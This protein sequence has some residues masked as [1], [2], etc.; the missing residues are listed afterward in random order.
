MGRSKRIFITGS[1][2]SALGNW[3][4]QLGNAAILIGLL[5]SIHKY[6]P[7]VIVTT[8]YQLSKGFSGTYRIQSLYL[9]PTKG[10]KA[11]R[12]L[13]TLYNLFLSIIWF[14]FW[15][16]LRLDIKF[17]RSTRLLNTYY[18]ADII[19]DLSGDT[20]GDN[21]PFK[22]FVKHSLELITARFLEKPIV[23]LAN[24]PG[25]FS[26]KFKK[27]IARITF[28][29]ISLITTREPISA[30]LLCSIGVKTPI[31]TTACPAFLLEPVQEYKLKEILQKEGIEEE[32]KPTVGFTLGGYNL[33][34]KPTWDTPESLEDLQLYVPTLKFL[35]EELHAQVVLIPHVYRMDPFSGQMI[36]GPDYIILKNLSRII[37]KDV[38][39]KNL[40]IIEGTYS[41]QEVKGLIGKMDLYISGRLHAGVAALSQCVPTVLLSYGHKHFGFAKLLNQEKYVWEPSMGPDGLLTIVKQIWE[42]KERVTDELHKRVPL[43]KELAE[44]NI[45]ILKDILDLDKELRV[46]LPNKLL[47]NWKSNICKKVSVKVW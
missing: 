5:T 44:L 37:S 15:R 20:Y 13:I 36:Q 33:Y 16:I 3:E 21:I 43:I 31:V 30:D 45:K 34:S 46:C 42:N 22:N 41:P 24:S 4:H 39:Y 26:G 40:K 38:E 32:Y 7:D 6:L 47:D 19:I 2:S 29:N 11:Y 35:L 8:K 9:E 17:L 28:N 27:F 25:P 10:F 12:M 1:C 14:F 18:N 23:S